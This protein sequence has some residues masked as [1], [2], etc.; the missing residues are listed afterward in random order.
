MSHLEERL[1]RRLGGIGLLK[2]SLILLAAGCA[3]LFLYILFGPED[4]NPIGLGLLAVAAVLLG[5]FGALL[6]LVVTIVQYFM[7][8]RK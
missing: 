8:G 5:G 7:R 4:G 3:P 1:I 6:G 2:W